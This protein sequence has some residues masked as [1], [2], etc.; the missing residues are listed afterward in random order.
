M[1]WGCNDEGALGRDTSVEDSETRPG[2]VQIPEENPEIYSISA[3]GSHSA[4]LLSNG[5]VYSWGTF[6]V[7]YSKKK[8]ISPSIIYHPHNVYRIKMGIWVFTLME[9]NN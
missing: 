8:N 9:I 3:G 2:I 4:V 1:S 7:S 5:N 6:R